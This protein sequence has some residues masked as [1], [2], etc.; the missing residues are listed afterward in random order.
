VRLSSI[1]FT[2]ILVAQPIAFASVLSGQKLAADDLG[3]VNKIALKIPLVSYPRAASNADVGGQ[4]RVRVWIN[5]KGA[6]T[7]AAVISGHRL[8]RKMALRSARGA[9]F[10]AGLGNCRSCKYATGVLVYTFVAP[11]DQFRK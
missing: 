11:S 10:P 7:R 5:K 2:L 6:V 1:I 3:E 9:E 4:V 8:L